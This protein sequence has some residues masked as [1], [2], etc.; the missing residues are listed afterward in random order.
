MEMSVEQLVTIV[1]AVS[2]NLAVVVAIVALIS[3]RNQSALSLKANLLSSLNSEFFF[4]ERIRQV[5]A[6]ASRFGLERMRRNVEPGTELAMSGFQMIDFFDIVAV[7]YKKG[8]LDPEM[9][10]VTFHFW[11][12]H[13]WAAFSS[14]IEK[15]ERDSGLRTYVDVRDLVVA[16]DRV[17]LKLKRVPKGRTISQ[18]ELQQFFSDEIGE[19]E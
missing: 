12:T 16:L 7:Y 11:L 6:S 13:Y 4:H 14:D 9:V 1:S 5:R 19:C 8:A 15:F 18:K 3:Q 2:A 10:C 17:A